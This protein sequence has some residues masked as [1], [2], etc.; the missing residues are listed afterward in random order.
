MSA[1]ARLVG[2]VARSADNGIPPER[3]RRRNFQAEFIAGDDD[4]NY[5]RLKG[6][7]FLAEE[8]YFSVRLVEMRLAEAHNYISEYV[9]MCSCY[10]R[11]TYGTAPREVPFTLSY[12]TI[13]AAL[14]KDA[15][16]SGP[17]NVEFQNVYVVRN[18]PVKADGLAMYTAL[19]RI[20]DSSLTRGMLDLLADAMGA[21]GGPAVGAVA[22][23]G[24]D[25]TKRLTALLGAEG[26]T[27]RFGVKDG[28]VLRRSGYR[29]FAG[30]ELAPELGNAD[31][32]VE[33]GRLALEAGG[34]SHTV[35]DVDYLIVALEHRETLVDDA[36][37]LS[38]TLSFHAG[39][40]HVKTALLRDDGKAADDALLALILRIS[41]SPDLTELDRL[42]MIATYKRQAEQWR[43]ASRKGFRLR[44]GQAEDITTRLTTLADA[45]YGDLGRPVAALLRSVSD[46][47][48][49]HR[50]TAGDPGGLLES[51][52]LLDA[53]RTVGRQLDSS[54]AIR[55]R[56]ALA[57]ATRYV[58]SA[59]V[60]EVLD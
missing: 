47:I 14:G 11:Y 23:T 26:V 33:G 19:C 2:M 58:V 49:T 15:G 1:I 3:L 50:A 7:A 4:P 22:R 59:A 16:R 5:A 45:R 43:A 40:D 42:R 41:T 35:N 30:S 18:V 34:R 38:S 36:F 60:S 28:S 52:G 51:D 48:A 44:S 17:R 6:D 21:I 46:A 29:V 12:E 54:G 39:W 20:A 55:D 24:T 56:E 31:L 57:T 37:G 32:R 53:A 27:T 8:S 25:L 9:P 13:R 10:L